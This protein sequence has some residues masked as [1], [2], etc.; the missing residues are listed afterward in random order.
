MEFL[1]QRAETR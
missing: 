1:S